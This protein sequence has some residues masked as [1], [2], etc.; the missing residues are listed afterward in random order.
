MSTIVQTLVE[1]ENEV[2]RND[3]ARLR[4]ASEALLQ[5]V[6]NYTMKAGSRSMLLQSAES[7]RRELDR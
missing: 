2:L 5:Q 6:E 4:K 1:I 3:L 7:L